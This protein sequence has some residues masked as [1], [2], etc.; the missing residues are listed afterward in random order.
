MEKQKS[1]SEDEEIED[2]N[3]KQRQ[4]QIK[5]QFNLSGY[6]LKSKKPGMAPEPRFSS[7]GLLFERKTFLVIFI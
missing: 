6:M 3:Q 4:E 2:K 1:P 5:N 7:R